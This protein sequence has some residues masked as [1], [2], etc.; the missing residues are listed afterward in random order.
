MVKKILYT[1]LAIILLIAIYLSIFELL[2]HTF[3]T[4]L[5]HTINN[6]SLH[7][8]TWIYL[9]KQHYISFIEI[10]DFNIYEKRHLLDVKRVL[11][12]TYLIWISLF[13]LALF[14][15]ILSFIKKFTKILLRYV[16]ITGVT[17]NMLLLLLS[18]NFLNSFNLFHRLFFSQNS[19][20]FPKDS[21]LIKCFPLL[22]FQEFSLLFL[23]LTFLTFAFL[24]IYAKISHENFNNR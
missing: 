19:W 6:P 2:L 13:S 9:L 20:Y 1:L 4:P 10:D 16:I 3:H 14:I 8:M 7:N 24:K 11:E 5:N 17:T 15:V 22:Y 21:L 18:F 23:I 12:T